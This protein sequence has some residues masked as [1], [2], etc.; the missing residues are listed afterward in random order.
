M[1]SNSFRH[2]STGTSIPRR[3]F[4]L[5][6]ACQERPTRFEID[7]ILEGV[8]WVY[9]F[10][11]DDE[12]V[13]EES[14]YHW[15]RGR[16]ALVFRRHGGSVDFGSGFKAEDRAIEGYLRA[17]T[18]LL[19]VAGATGN[20]KLASLFEWFRTNL[21]L[22][23]SDNRDI[24]E[25]YTAVIAGKEEFHRR[26]VRMLHAA[27]LGIVDIAIAPPEGERLEYLMQLIKENE[28]GLEPS[29]IPEDL[30]YAFA[31]LFLTHTGD[32]VTVQFSSQDES[33]GT[34]AWVSLIGPILEALDE[35]VVFLMDELDASLHPHLVEKVISMF[36]DPRTNPRNAQIVFNSH[37]GKL[38]EGDGAWSLGRDQI[39]FTE[40]YTGGATQLYSLDDFRPRR[41]EAIHHRY[42][43]GRYGATPVLDDSTMRLALTPVDK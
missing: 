10:E 11:V 13:R 34:L 18:L 21:D 3:P 25:K 15:P 43:Q 37:D 6:P 1:N 2:G 8:R 16:P 30:A 9:G 27:D 5:D 32:E 35:G 26:I 29:D 24:R 17:N 39:W 41:D 40:K 23:E 28:G 19:S 42:Y 4:L 22:A 33:R 12:R 20:E 38:L 36:Q 31:E 14:A 7:L